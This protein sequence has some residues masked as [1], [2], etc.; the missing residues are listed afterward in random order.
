MLLPAFRISINRRDRTV[1]VRVNKTEIDAALE[2]L[3]KQLRAES[4]KED[5]AAGRVY[6]LR[7]F[8]EEGAFDKARPSRCAG[9]R[10]QFYNET[11]EQLSKTDRKGFAK[12]GLKRSSRLF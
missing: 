11:N 8:R 10:I 3:G 12:G 6:G 4:D 9:P 5:A 7:P 1:V 2:R